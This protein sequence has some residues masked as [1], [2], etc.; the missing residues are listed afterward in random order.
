MHWLGF[1]TIQ[2]RAAALGANNIPE[3]VYDT[4]VA[5][6]NQHLDLVYRWYELKKRVLGLDKMY[7]YDVNVPLAG[8]DMLK[9]TFEQGKQLTWDDGSRVSERPE[10]R[11]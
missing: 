3:S 6:V 2:V 1:V 5:T 10:K 9:T 11:I 7:K 8:E 4:L